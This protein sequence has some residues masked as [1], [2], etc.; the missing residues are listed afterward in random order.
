MSLDV[1]LEVKADTGNPKTEMIEV[2][3]ANITHNLNTMAAKAGIY[4]HCW[5]PEEIGIERAGDLIQ[6]LKDGLER[7]KK[8]PFFYEQFNAPN[9]WGLY[10]HFVPWVEKYLNAC[11]ENPNAIISVSR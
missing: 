4:Y 7:L 6:P 5:R 10:M 11:I 9:G 3:W 2:Y 1:Y 8:Y